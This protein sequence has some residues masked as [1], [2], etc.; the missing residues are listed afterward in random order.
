VLPALMW[1]A[2]GCSANRARLSECQGSV[3]ATV[4]NNWNHPVDVYADTR[5]S[6][7]ILGEVQPGSREEFSLPEGATGVYFRWRSVGMVVQPT[8]SDIPV[9]YG[10]R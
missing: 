10:C 4:R 7:F 6:G 5:A 1:A 8:S 3:I 9:S 2:A